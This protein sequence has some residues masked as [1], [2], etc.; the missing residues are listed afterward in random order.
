MST[1]HDRASRKLTGEGLYPGI[2][3]RAFKRAWFRT[4]RNRRAGLLRVW[5]GVITR[6]SRFTPQALA[7]YLILDGQYAEAK[8]TLEA[9][10]RSK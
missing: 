9:A 1:A 8:R 4:P 5:K 2:R 10:A 6:Q 3:A 7:G